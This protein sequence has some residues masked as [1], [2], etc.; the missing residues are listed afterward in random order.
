MSDI[1]TQAIA[2]GLDP[3]TAFVPAV[4]ADAPSLIAPTAPA[5][6]LPAV[7]AASVEHVQESVGSVPMMKD[8]KLVRIVLSD[9]DHIPPEGQFFGINGQSYKLEA[10]VEADV[11]DYLL[12]LLDNALETQSIRDKN[13]RIIGYREVPR[14]PYR[15]VR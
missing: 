14:F 15:V 10:G 12:E 7:P 4:P 1:T 5:E 8:A 6:V 2:A 11:P 13:G 9:G 3:A